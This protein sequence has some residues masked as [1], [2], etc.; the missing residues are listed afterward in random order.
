MRKPILCLDF[1]GVLHSYKSGWQGAAIV[2][3][4]PVP[5]AV[6]FL[7]AAVE[8]FRVAIYS[9][10]SGQPGGIDAMRGWLTMFVLRDI[11]DRRE[12][13]HVLSLIEWPTEKP[14]ALIGIDDRVLTFGG[15]WPSMDDLAAFK[16][17]NKLDPDREASAIE[18]AY[19]ALWRGSLRADLPTTTARKLLLE[20]I[21]KDGQ[22]RGIAW[23]TKEF[24]QV[25]DAEIL[26][27]DVDALPA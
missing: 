5:G 16:P 13:E 10:R 6:A 21:G 20:I 2:P 14:A 15:T 26:S 24:G 4:P 23:A 17:W 25:T 1:D 9:S 22:R 19:G 7:H 3:D 18:K 8:R 11:D 12:A 27:A